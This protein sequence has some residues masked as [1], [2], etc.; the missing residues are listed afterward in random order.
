M[1]TIK[2]IKNYYDEDFEIFNIDSIDIEKGITVLVG[3]NGYGKT[4]FLKILKQQLEDEKIPYIYYSDMHDGRQNAM[5]KAGLKND[6]KIMS[7]LM[8]SSEG[9]N[10]II[11]FGNLLEK[12]YPFLQTGINKFNSN[13]FDKVFGD[14]NEEEIESNERWLL[15]DSIDS[16]TSIDIIIEIKHVLK[17]MKKD[18]ELLNKDLYII[19]ST[20]AYEFTKNNNCLDIVN[21]ERLKFKDYEEYK[22]FVLNSAKIKSKRF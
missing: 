20:N 11:N 22:N 16:G 7:S 2:I 3:C 8:Q 4:T 14:K 10:M 5:S 15:I 6:F 13:P 9:E 1:K 17:L 18:A 21:G 12:V 19:I